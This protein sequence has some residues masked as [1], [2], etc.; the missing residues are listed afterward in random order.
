[1]PSFI[2]SHPRLVRIAGAV[3]ALVVLVWVCVRLLSDSTSESTNDAYV[4]ADFT[5]VA[6]RIAGQ[7]SDVLVDDNQSVKSGELLVRIDDRDYRAAL[8]SAQAEVAAARAA[9]ANFDA[10]IARHPS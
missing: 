7:I 2:R 5:L 10:E 6:P 8:M 1:M 4:E 3:V 9:V